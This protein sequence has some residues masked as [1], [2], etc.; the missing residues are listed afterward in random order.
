MATK[1]ELKLAISITRLICEISPRFLR[2]TG[3]FGVWSKNL[4]ERRQSNFSATDPGCHGNEIW[5]KIGYNSGCVRDISEILASGGGVGLLNDVSQ[6]RL[7]PT[8]VGMATKFE[9]KFAISRLICE[10]CPRFVHP[11]GGFRSRAIERCLSKSIATD[12]CPWQRI[13]SQNWLQL[14]LYQIYIRDTCA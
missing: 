13:L 6:I 8:L 9:L 12:P 11:P 2:I 5:V 14:G 3:V 1:F 10:I 4:T 7:Q